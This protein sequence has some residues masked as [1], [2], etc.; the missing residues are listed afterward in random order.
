MTPAWVL[1]VDIGGTGSRALLA[2]LDPT[3]QAPPYELRGDRVGVGRAGSSVPAVTVEL[4]DRALAERPQLLGGLRAIAVGATGLASVVQDP[5]AMLAA[6]SRAGGGVPAAIA[7]DAVTAHL[8][9]LAGMA[10]AV[11]TVGTGSIAFGSDFRTVWRRVDGWGHLLGDRGAGVWIGMQAMQSAM[12]THDGVTGG[13]HDGTALLAAVKQRFG[14]PES[15]PAQL[16]TRQ[17]RA[18]VLAALAPDVAELA[19]SGDAQSARIM[20]EAG[21][22]VARSLAAALTPELPAVAAYSGGVFSAGGVYLDSFLDE[23]ARIA[24]HATLGPA[25][26]TPLDG[27]VRLARM[28]ADTAARP[29]NHPPYLWHDAA[30]HAPR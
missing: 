15:W 4:I 20:A 10:G 25:S 26:G 30:P 2:P 19:A 17:D 14:L 21:R 5:D 18:G 6:V 9:A 28:I 8:G 13:P 22:E 11:L 16:Y 12:A 7:V 29:S 24:P 1:G 27:A 3:E 23:F